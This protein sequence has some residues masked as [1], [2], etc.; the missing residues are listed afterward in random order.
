MGVERGRRVVTTKNNR[1]RGKLLP[2]SGKG[3][4]VPR[5]RTP[6]GK[7][8]HGVSFAPETRFAKETDTKRS[9]RPVFRKGGGFV[10]EGK[11]SWAKKGAP[12]AGEKVQKRDTRGKCK[13]RGQEKAR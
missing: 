13:S 7:E 9:E 11:G 4:P 5:T 8:M 3:H 2:S 10:Q 1:R 12:L 6:C